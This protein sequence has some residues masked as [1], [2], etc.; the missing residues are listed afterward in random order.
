MDSTTSFDI[1]KPSISLGK[2]DK[3]FNFFMFIILI[4]I[5]FIILVPWDKLGLV[6]KK[7]GMSGGTLTQLMAQDS[8]DI[9]LKSNVNKLATGNFDLFWNQPTRVANTFMNR[10]SP[11]SSIYLPDTDINPTKNPLI[12]SNNYIDHILNPINTNETTD[13]LPNII[14][15][16]IT[17]SNNQSNPI[18]LSNVAKQITNTKKTTDNLPQLINNSKPINKLYQSYYNNLLYNK[19]CIKNPS[20]CG[21]G[22]GGFRLGED[23]NNSTTSKQF[24]NI[25]GNIF[26]PDSYVGSYFI[27]PDFSIMRPIPFM[28]KSNLY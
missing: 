17:N 28:P 22:A 16:N 21:N 13:Y 23:Y 18:E 2:T 9:Y 8:Q 27:E 11:L 14:L 20:M 12:D 5:F 4:I 19:D 25:D 1:S 3:A 26:Y 15:P 24:V 10:G 6:S 7:E